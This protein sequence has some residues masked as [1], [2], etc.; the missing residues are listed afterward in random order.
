MIVGGEVWMLNF[1]LIC[2]FPYCPLGD[3]PYWRGY[4]WI[5]ANYLIL[6]SLWHLTRT[7]GPY[8]SEAK[9]L[10]TRLRDALLRTILGQYQTTGYFWEQYSDV[11]GQGMRCHPFTGWTALVLNIMAEDF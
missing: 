11:D 9:E 8:Q 10:Y 2:C 4:V 6:R 7:V 3:A 1:F 5:N